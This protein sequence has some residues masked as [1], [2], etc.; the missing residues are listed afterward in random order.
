MFVSGT[1]HCPMWG[2][3]GSRHSLSRCKLPGRPITQRNRPYR[4]LGGEA[5]RFWEAIGIAQDSVA[6]P[7]AIP[8]L[9]TTIVWYCDK[10]DRGGCRSLFLEYHIFRAPDILA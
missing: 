1:R 10:R 6:G 8:D 3:R 7:C 2:C 5:D 9:S 4:G